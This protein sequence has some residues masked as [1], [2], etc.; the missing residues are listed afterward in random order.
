LQK[1]GVLKEIS[2]AKRDRVFCAKELLDILE[3]P[4]QLRSAEAF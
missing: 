4:P 2:G 1:Q 3:E